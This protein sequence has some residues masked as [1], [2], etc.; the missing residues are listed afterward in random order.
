MKMKGQG[1]SSKQGP[2]T[3]L[4]MERFIR[5]AHQVVILNVAA[6]WH[7]VVHEN[8]LITAIEFP[9]FVH[10]YGVCWNTHIHTLIHT[11][12]HHHHHPDDS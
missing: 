3:S 6:S 2:G 4:F 9:V 11:H 8:K 12:H 10:V 1:W 7:V 5:G